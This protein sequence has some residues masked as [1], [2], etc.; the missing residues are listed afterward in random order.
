MRVPYNAQPVRSY[1]QNVS[2][3]AIAATAFIGTLPGTAN[4]FVDLYLPFHP[5][6]DANGAD[7]GALSNTSISFTSTCLLAEVAQFT[8][9]SQMVSGNYW[10]NYFT[11]HIRVYTG[12]TSSSVT[13]NYKYFQQQTNASSSG[14][15]TGTGA[16]V[17][18]A[19]FEEFSNSRG[20][21]TVTPNNG[22]Q[23][24]TLSAF[25]TGSTIATGMTVN[26]FVNGSV[27]QT[28]S[29]GVVTNIPLT[30]VAWNDTTK[31]LTLTG[32]TG[33]FA[34]SDVVEVVVSGPSNVAI[35]P[36]GTDTESNTS[37]RLGVS[38]WLKTFNGTTWERV[39]SGI[40]AVTSTLTGM[41][42][43][44]PM[45]I[46]NTVAPAPTN[47]Q[48]VPM[49]S[50]GNGNEL[51]SLGTTIAGE[52]LSTDHMKVETQMTYQ[53]ITTAT[54]T[55][56]KSGAGFLHNLVINTPGA[57][58]VITLY[59]NTAGSGTKIGT[60]TMPASLLSSGPEVAIYNV[61]FTIG[62][63]IVTA[64]TAQDITVGTR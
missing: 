53:N 61:K 16:G 36:A 28:T 39:R 55:T 1:N 50:D 20:D 57:L 63:T 13:I 5:I 51:M 12:D 10:I 23:T 40:A 54:T 56:V 18:G 22:T 59:D 58:G 48:A 17:S 34:T 7:T 6:A 45:M 15:G 32:M 42:N 31:V 64:T 52:D 46:Y 27:K 60:I 44:I 38:A 11:G 19:T 47:G 41:I 49:Q 8:P 4:T 37:N 21:F 35:N 3:Q 14:G 25:A 24:V 33:N 2:I 43:Q 62:L 29:A 26:N 9:D 30:N